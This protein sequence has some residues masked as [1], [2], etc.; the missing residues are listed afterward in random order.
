MTK[1]EVEEKAKREGKVLFYE[2][3]EEMNDLDEEDVGTWKN[4]YATD[5]EFA[6]KSTNEEGDKKY[7][8][9]I[10]KEN[11]RDDTEVKIVSEEEACL[12]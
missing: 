7:I 9:E 12:R 6:V 11:V 2:V 3:E 5:S 10:S 1:K 4:I 8:P